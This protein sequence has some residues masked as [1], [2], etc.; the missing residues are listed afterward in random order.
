MRRLLLPALLGLAL[1]AGC[2]DKHA[3]LGEA[4]AAEGDW[5]AAAEHYQ[6]AVERSPDDAD[7]RARY[8]EAREE[9]ADGLVEQ[10]RAAIEAG[11]VYPALDLLDRADALLPRHLPVALAR[12]EAVAVVAEGVRALLAGDEEPLA[13][14]CEAWVTFAERFPVHPETA[15]LRDLLGESLSVEVRRLVEAGAY[16]EALAVAESLGE[17]LPVEGQVRLVR[18]A[19]AES[20]AEEARTAARRNKP[21][22]AWVTMALA[23]GLSGDTQQAAQRDAYRAAFLELHG[24]TLGLRLVSADRSALTRLDSNLKARFE[25]P[26]LR[27]MPG[28]PRATIGGRVTITE[29]RWEQSSKPTVAVHE[30]PGPEAEHD[31]PAWLEAGAAVEAAEARLTAAQADE[32][33]AVA[34]RAAEARSLEGMRA[35]LATVEGAL[36]EARQVVA[37]AQAEVDTAQAALDEC[38]GASESVTQLEEQRAALEERV[39]QA[40]DP[41]ERAQAQ[42]AL[43]AAPRPTNLMREL[44]RHVGTR[45]GQLAEKVRVLEAAQAELEE[46]ERP[47]REQLEAVASIEASLEEID[48][49]LEAAREAQ[50]V[51]ERGIE[52]ARAAQAELPPTVFGPTVERIEIPVQ[53]HLRSCHGGMD[54]LLQPRGGSAVERSL[55]ARAETRDEERPAVPER[56]LA[57]DPLEFPRADLE[58]Q[59]SVEAELVRGLRA[60]LEAAVADLARARLAEAAGQDD[61]ELQLRAL[62]QAW[63]LLP[64]ATAAVADSEASSE[65]GAEALLR[66]ALEERWGLA[67]PGWLLGTPEG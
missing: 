66:A 2:G 46:L 19:W 25:R 67:E 5:V 50:E 63:L 39:A 51:A 49:V 53:A 48:R 15:R 34:S 21:A 44:A 52:K 6:A 54:I 31:N 30:Y 33:R 37:A 24:T 14:A 35:G 11:E 55:V 10:A 4:A 43:E 26:G 45:A 60:E 7:L 29:P 58:L 62:L 16:A 20:L 57:A 22:S 23:A 36:A 28:A 56:D 32:E 64:R 47:V 9:A 61:P 27:W 40:Q 18:G 3:A 13:R 38:V 12:E 41:E 59:A 42:A 17:H 1:G 8:Q 65:P